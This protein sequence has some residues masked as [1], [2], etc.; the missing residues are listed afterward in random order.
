MLFRPG[1]H[2]FCLKH[3]ETNA[4]ESLL[5]G[6]S[7]GDYEGLQLRREGRLGGETPELVRI[8]GKMC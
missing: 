7:S 5:D 8:V 3:I 6:F 2:W 4:P 1:R